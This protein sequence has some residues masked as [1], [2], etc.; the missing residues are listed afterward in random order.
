MW[1]TTTGVSV[2]FRGFLFLTLVSIIAEEVR[3]GDV[4]SVPFRG[5]LFLTKLIHKLYYDG[6]SF[7]FRPLPGIFVFNDF[8]RAT[9]AAITR[10]KLP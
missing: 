3:E 8:F 1:S 7:G 6:C 5:F 4:V 10:K 2:P 9:Q